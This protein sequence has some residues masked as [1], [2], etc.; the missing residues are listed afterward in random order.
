MSTMLIKLDENMSVAH[1]EFLRQM[2]YDCDRVTDEGLSGADD[3]IVWQEACAEGRFFITLDLDFSDVRRFPPGTHPGIL[4]LR[5]RSRS[6]QY[7]LD[8]LS[9]VVSEQPLETL[10][11]CLVVADEMQTRIRRP[12]V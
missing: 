1:A 6:R 3:E 4:L 7:V 11:G 12:P 10:Q 2:G 5:S 9:R 8:V